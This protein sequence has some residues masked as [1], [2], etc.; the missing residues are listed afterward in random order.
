MSNTTQEQILIEQRITNE[1]KS[2]VVAYLLLLF[3]GWFGVHR[4]YLGASGSGAAMLVLFIVG[5][6]TL[7][8]GI[9]IA[10]LVAVGIW[11]FVDL[12]LIPGMVDKARHAL[13]QQLTAQLISVGSSN[14]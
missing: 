13:R 10:F 11:A 14:I 8:I 12:F 5:L 6:I 3:L 4:F 2:P 9:G 1:S 7:P